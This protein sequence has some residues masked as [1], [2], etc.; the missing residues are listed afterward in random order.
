M[1]QNETC[2]Y[3]IIKEIEM[4]NPTSVNAATEAPVYQVK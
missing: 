3:T 1:Q 2:N 4:V